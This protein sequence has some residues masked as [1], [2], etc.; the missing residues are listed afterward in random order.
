MDSLRAYLRL[1]RWPNLLM[2]ALT[3][4]LLRHVI[5]LPLFGGSGL[6]EHLFL[7]FVLATLF[8]SAAGY[9]VNDFYD[10]RTD[11]INRPDKQVLVRRLPR[12]HA[13]R[14]YVVLVILSLLTTAWLSHQMA[15][16]PL[17]WLFAG[18]ALSSWLYSAVLKRTFLVGNLFI[19]ILAALMV[20]LVWMIE[21][22]A[23]VHSS[24]YPGPCFFSAAPVVVAYA[25]F[26]AFSTLLRELLKDLEDFRG[27]LRAGRKTLPV[28]LGVGNTKRVA[29]VL[30]LIILGGIA[31]TKVLVFG[32]GTLW[33][34]AYL[35]VAVLLPFLVLL[36]SLMGLAGPSNFPL[37]QRLVKF[38]M[39]TGILSM[40][41]L[42]AYFNQLWNC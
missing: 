13:L 27:D 36:F 19:S 37:A 26:A 40:L 38:A 11:R 42:S 9:A 30:T 4:Y 6:P 15:Y 18:V 2:I 39:L 24:G 35:L 20:L 16:Y 10:L 3:Q 1:F 41:I 8:L 7:L 31:V 33:L 22:H 34:S 14:A 21:H 5:I 29:T 12:H 17:L 28:V 25:L 32:A 23:F